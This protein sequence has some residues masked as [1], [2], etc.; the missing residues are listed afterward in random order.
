VLVQVYNVS[1]PSNRTILELTL[2]VSFIE[3]K[4][5]YR[6]RWIFFPDC[7]GGFG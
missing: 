2:F 5:R 6:Y 4:R 3:Y 1:L 7:I